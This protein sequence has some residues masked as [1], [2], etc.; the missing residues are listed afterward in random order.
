MPLGQKK[1]MVKWSEGQK[2]QGVESRYRSAAIL[3][4]RYP[5]CLLAH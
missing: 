5:V 2:V 4:A 3:L 1:Q